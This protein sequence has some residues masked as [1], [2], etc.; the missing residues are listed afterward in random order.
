MR[1][2]AMLPER[3]HQELITDL[4]ASPA[5]RTAAMPAI[6]KHMASIEGRLANGRLMNETEIRRLQA[7]YELLTEMEDVE[8]A[9]EFFSPEE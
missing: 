2:R 3:E 5:W 6:H 1:R 8:S 4:L 7:K 9:R